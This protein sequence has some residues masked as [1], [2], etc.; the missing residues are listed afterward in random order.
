MNLPRQFALL[1][2][3]LSAQPVY[4]QKTPNEF[5]PHKLGE[6]FTPHHLLS[7]YFEQLAAA[8][9]STMRLEKYGLTNELRPLEIA[10]FSSAENMARLEQIRINNLRLA[11]MAEGQ[12]DLNNPIA[13]VWISMSVHG[14]EASGSECSMELA[15]RLATQSDEK[16][17]EWLKNTVVILDPALNPDGYDRYTHWHRMAANLLMNIDPDAREH[18]EPWPG[19]R[20]NHYY[21]DL[22]RDW[23]WATQLE[24]QQRLVVYHRWLPHVHPDIHEQ[25][26]NEPYYFAPAAEPMHELITQ[27]QRNFQGEIGENN[28]RHFDNNGWYYFTR[29]VFDLFYPSYGDTYPTF[30]G[31]IGMTYEQGGGPRGGRAVET[32][33]ED[34]LT[35][36][37]R[38]EHHLTTSLSTIEVSS[39]SAKSLVENFRDYFRLTSTEPHGQYK[40]FIIREANDPNKI[41]VLCQLLDRHQV[42][43][44]RVGY[45]LSGVKAFDYASGKDISA[46][47][48]PNDLVVSAYQP[49]SVM[50]QALFEP[51][52]KLADSMTYDITAWSLIFAHGLDAYALKVR[53]EPKKAYETYQPSKDLATASPYAWCVHRKS[54]AEMQFLG[55]LL[56]KGVRVRTAMEPFTLADQ[57]YEA[58]AFVVSK[59]DNRS[60]QGGLDS[61]VIKAA[62]VAKVRLYPVFTGFSTMGKDLGS[63]V[64][65]LVNHPKI[66]VVYGDDV[67]P[68]S[69]GHTWFFFERELGYPVTPIPLNKLRKIDLKKYTTLIFPHGHYNLEEK[70]LETLTKWAEK[71]GRIV[72]FE[73][74]VKAFADKDGFDLKT[75]ESPK[76]D[77]SAQRKPFM[78]RQRDG[79]SDGLPGAIVRTTVDNTHPLAFG[80]PKYYHSLKTLSD[81]FQM[82]ESADTPIYLEENYQTFGFIGSRVKPQLKNSPIAIVQRM[83]EGEAVFFVDNPLFRCF[84]QQGKALFANALFF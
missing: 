35:L 26:I 8:R 47:I 25:G 27:W 41:R 17:K 44:G 74:G 64:F 73:G 5:L 80:F 56:E 52:A 11:G 81:A 82:P 54:L 2:L 45:G 4:T 49:H 53:L 18:L 55:T 68:N 13:I 40:S 9:T 15:Y 14:N 32:D 30:N 63:D 36:H 10:I 77:S 38:I 29:E 28:A 67:D 66:A 33:N 61:I 37:D 65:K 70:T 1:F 19:G 62:E 79:L 78:T 6:Q 39:K 84:W 48:N 22:N 59:A 20:S 75:K 3:F 72:A 43:Y 23:A 57:Q 71:G 76:R 50:V 58:G 51:E 7:A 46:S 42:K 24:T 83:D 34:T 69:Y 21:F 60:V 12:P 16:I 31:A